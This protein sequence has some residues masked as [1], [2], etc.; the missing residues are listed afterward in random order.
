MPYRELLAELESYA[1]ETYRAFHKRLLKNDNIAVLGVKT[2]YLRKTAK[3]YKDAVDELF[4]YPDEYYEVTFIKLTAAALLPFEKF[5]SYVDKCVS[6]IDNWATCD[7][8]DAKCIAKHREEFLPYIKKYARADGEFYQR[9]AL[10][11]L[12]HFYV[13]ESYLPLIFELSESSD[14]TQYYVYM[15]AAW[16]IAEVLIKHYDEGVKFL[17]KNSLDKKTHNKAIQ[18]AC[19]SFR[20]SDDRKKYLKGIK[21]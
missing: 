3:K 10:V 5:L 13:E 9:Y 11:T 12:L 2:P 16:L 18:K 1:D 6:L 19:E 21:R 15:A 8:F 4:A 17:L 14:K 20:L 7:C